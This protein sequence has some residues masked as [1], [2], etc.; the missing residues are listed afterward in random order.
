MV[1]HRI[2]VKS[3][4]LH[5]SRIITDGSF[6]HKSRALVEQLER[7]MKE[8]NSHMT[9]DNR[10]AV[11]EEEWHDSW[12]NQT[13]DI[14]NQLKALKSNIRT[15]Q[16]IQQVAFP[17]LDH[18]TN[19]LLEIIARIRAL[20]SPFFDKENP[21]LAYR[22]SSTNIIRTLQL[23][24]GEIVRFIDEVACEDWKEN[25]KLTEAQGAISRD[26]DSVVTALNYN[27][28]ALASIRSGVGFNTIGDIGTGGGWQ[29]RG[30]ISTQGAA[31][32][33]KLT[34]KKT[35]KTYL[36]KRKEHLGRQSEATT[37]AKEEEKPLETGKTSVT[38]RSSQRAKRN[39]GEWEDE[40]S[41]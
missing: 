26:I 36:T 10:A 1:S 27:N 22:M 17:T 19:S 29:R 8:L 35:D 14:S 11:N 21:S 18:W 31:L 41:D 3:K 39:S 34:K 16:A 24:C 12:K 40:A 38:A 25:S 15:V 5:I 33:L 37:S 7:A 13:V 23:L 32:K 6:W 28:P 9:G 2:N 30:E 20:V 4:L